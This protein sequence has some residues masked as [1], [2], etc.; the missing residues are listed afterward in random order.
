MSPEINCVHQTSTSASVPWI[1]IHQFLHTLKLDNSKDNFKFFFDI[2][3]FKF[4]VDDFRRVF[5]LPQVTDNNNDAFVDAPT[6]SEMLPFFGNVLKFSLPMRLSTH[7]V[8]KRITSTVTLQHYHRVENDEI[9][10]SIFNSRKNKE[11]GGMQIPD[12]MLTKD[13]KLTIHYQLY[14]FVFRV[15][16]P[17]TQSQPFESTRGTHRTLGAPKTPNPVTTQERSLADLEA[18]QNVEKV[19]EHLVNEEIETMVEGTDNVDEDEFMDEIF[20]SQEVTG[21]RQKTQTD[22]A[23][24]I[25]KAVKRIENKAKTDDDARHEGESSAKRQRTSEHGAYSVGESSS[26][27]VMDELNPSDSEV[28]PKLMKEISVNIDE[29][30]LQNAVNDWKV[31]KKTCRYKF[32]SCERDP[33]APLMTLL[34]QDLFYLKYGNSRSKKYV[35]SLHKYPAVPFPENDLEELTSRWVSKCF[36]RVLKLVEKFNL[37]VKHGYA[38]PK[39]DDADAKYIVKNIFMIV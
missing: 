4:S 9:V 24:L 19:L 8:T 35:L 23:T 1:Y 37:D 30:T 10:K 18:Q 20:N 31:E 11:G 27:Q 2:N 25:A 21:T 7:F 5:Q 12:W 6:F 16:V 33:K 17:T 39:L 28:S 26:K 36:K 3:E 38:N 15:D 34:N 22:M 29:S 13:M 32:Q 14:L